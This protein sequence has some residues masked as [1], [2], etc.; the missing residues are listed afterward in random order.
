M[1]PLSLLAHRTKQIA[2][3]VLNLLQLWLQT[4]GLQESSQFSSYG[5]LLLIQTAMT[6]DPDETPQMIES[7]G[8]VDLRIKLLQV[9]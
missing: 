6:R 7:R 9:H 8:L 5:S 2:P 1:G 4:V 3:A